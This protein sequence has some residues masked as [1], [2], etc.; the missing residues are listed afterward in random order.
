MANSTVTQ[1]AIAPLSTTTDSV[2]AM[3]KEILGREPDESG[4]AYYTG[5]SPEYVKQQLLGSDEYKAK[6]ASASTTPSTMDVVQ[7][8]RDSTTGNPLLSQT[9]TNNLTNPKLPSGTAQV[10]K[11]LESTPLTTPDQFLSTDPASGSFVQ[12]KLDPLTGEVLPYSNTAGSVATITPTTTSAYKPGSP[13]WATAAGYSASTVGKIADTKIASAPDLTNM[14]MSAPPDMIPALMEYLPTLEARQGVAEQIDIDAFLQSIDTQPEQMQAI[15]ASLS[16]DELIT[17]QLNNLLKGLEGGNIPNW[18]RPIVESVE[19]NLERRGIGK[20]SIARD[21]LFNAI[22][23]AA[24]P[25]A[26]HNAEAIQYRANLNLG[27]LNEAEKFNTAL[28]QEMKI[29]VNDKVAL[30]VGQNASLRQQMNLANL[31]AQSRADLA[32]LEYQYAVNKGNM[33]ATNMAR[34]ENMRMEMQARASNQEVQ[35]RFGLAEM[36][37][38]QQ[39]YVLDTQVELQRLLSNQAA[40]NAAAQFNAASA[41]QVNMFNANL[42][43]QVEQY[44]AAVLNSAAEFNASARS[45]ERRVGKECR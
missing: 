38:R 13:Y 33:D 12:D 2:T 31:D 8:A 35:A 25:L 5:K 30:F 4:L 37:N 7:A 42:A 27:F 3:Y 44:N 34:L 43:M 10:Y 36:S 21:A 39:A 24:T 18:A 20:S 23:Q 40:R 15:V 11:P 28:R 41:N 29:S 45:E 9:L 16:E 6:N 17:G 1:S 19:A 22:I 32:N 26:Q 14:L